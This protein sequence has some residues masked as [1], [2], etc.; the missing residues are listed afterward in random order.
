MHDASKN[1][2]SRSAM[3]SRAIVAAIVFTAVIALPGAAVAQGMHLTAPGVGWAS[4]NGLYWTT[5]NGKNWKNITPP[6][7]GGIVSVF[8]LD[9]STGWVLGG[10]GV[11]ADFELA[12]TQD[13]GSSWSVTKLDLGVDPNSATLL[14]Q[15]HIEFLDAAHG[16]INLSLE[17][18]SAYN[19]GLLFRTAD[20][21]KHWTRVKGPG[22]GTAGEVRFIDERSG[23]I[24]G[25]GT[26]RVLSVTH[27]GGLTWSYVALRPPAYVHPSIVDEYSLPL[28]MDDKRGVV[29]VTYSAPPA[30]PDAASAGAEV[31]AFSTSDGGKE[32]KFDR[33]LA[34]LVCPS[35]CDQSSNLEAAVAGSR[36]V[37][38][39]R[40]GNA[41]TMK[42]VP[43]AKQGS[44]TV[45]N[46]NIGFSGALLSLSVASEE[47]AWVVTAT[48]S[49]AVGRQACTQLFSTT[50]AG[51]SW[52]DITPGTAKVGKPPTP[53]GNPIPL[54]WKPG[55][56]KRPVTFFPSQRGEFSLR[57][58]CLPGM[59]GSAD[60][61]SL[62]WKRLP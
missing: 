26:G 24:L 17:S 46:A 18:S 59:S 56:W 9:S 39:Q 33:V 22:P 45:R 53:T 52:A 49:C 29:V 16:W 23:W 57:I 5:D 12:F 13:S 37:T 4:T 41:L 62:V 11:P 25:G 54:D 61:K 47:Q 2:N 30:A 3:V 35:G 42:S 8:F 1:Q 27:D 31:V 19:L 28:F 50:D 20:S 55:G 10:E 6:I 44:A 58:R 15:G 14:A 51:A 21:G 38:A 34:H 60:A 32:W 36:L 40:S 48:S 43:V 7:H